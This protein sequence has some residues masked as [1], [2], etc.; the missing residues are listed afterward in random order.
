MVKV[1]KALVSVVIVTRNRKQDALICIQSIYSQSYKKVEVILVDNASADDTSKVAK[2]KF[3]N[4]LVIKSL[5]NTGGAG[6]RNLG[7]PYA[8]GM[9]T[10]F[11]DDDA[12]ADKDMIKELVKVMSA[13]KKVGIVQPKI[14][15]LE[16]KNMIQGVGHGISLVTG[17]VYGIGVHVK[18]VGQFEQVLDIPLAG[19]T[20]MVRNSVFKKIG[21]YDEDYFIP[22]EDSDFSFRVKKGGYKVLF[23]PKAKVWHRGAKKTFIHPWIEWIGITTP[24]RAY[25]VSRNKIIFMRKHAPF[26]NLLIFLFVFIPIYTILHSLIMII[27]KRVDLLAS[28]WKGLMSGLGYA[29]LHK[30]VI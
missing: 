26:K 5:V 2:K 21:N 18:D 22:Y 19:C 27:T 11:M 25:R 7:I 14:Y 28:Y 12:R 23:I 8:K 6:G 17:R 24:E 13:D 29:I 4:L 9:Y 16:R 15:E 30:K 10:L 3:P 20:W 1:K